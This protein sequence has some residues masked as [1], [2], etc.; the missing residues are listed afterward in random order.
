LSRAPGN[1]DKRGLTGVQGFS[2]GWTMTLFDDLFLNIGAIKSGTSWLAKQL[3][4]HPEIFLTPV[5]EIHYFAHIHSPIQFLDKNGRIEALKTY[6][7]WLSG[8]I[9]TDLL[10]HN[11]RWFDMYLDDPV[12]DAWFYNLYKNRGS[13]R[14]CTEFSNITSIL[15]DEVWT[16]VKGITNNLKVLYTLRDPFMRLWSHARFQASIEGKFDSLPQWT[17]AEY[18]AFIQSGDMLRHCFYS[19]TISTLRRNLE[20]YQ[21][22][23]LCFEDFRSN[24]LKELRRL[25]N[26]LSISRKNYY[27]LEFHNPSLPLE[28]PEPFLL[29]SRDIIAAEFDRLDKLGVP[30]PKSWTLPDRPCD[31]HQQDYRAPD[32]LISE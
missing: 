2:G 14:Y 1:L 19:R 21:F 31:V 28:M 15:D 27:D 29:A 7:A 20:P 5:K 17:E 23:V 24:P 9:N 11:L 30:I 18:R 26:F 25:E 8:D 16:H 3:E 4:D 22:L 32:R 12:N 13:K 6:A 10:K